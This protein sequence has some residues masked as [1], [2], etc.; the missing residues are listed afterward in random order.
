MSNFFLLKDFSISFDYIQN[1]KDE[2]AV[3][4]SPEFGIH[5]YAKDI[6]SSISGVAVSSLYDRDIISDKPIIDVNNYLVSYCG[7]QIQLLEYM[8]R[9]VNNDDGSNDNYPSV[10][11]FLDKNSYAVM[12]SWF[13]KTYFPNMTNEAAYKFYDELLL[14]SYNLQLFDRIEYKLTKEDFISVYDNT[15]STIDSEILSWASD[16]SVAFKYSTVS[17]K[18]TPA[19]LEN[20]KRLVLEQ[21]QIFYVKFLRETYKKLVENFSYFED[22]NF[23]YRQ[24][25]KIVWKIS[26]DILIDGLDKITLRTFYNLITDPEDSTTESQTQSIVTNFKDIFNLNKEVYSVANSKYFEFLKMDPMHDF[27]INNSFKK[28]NA[29]EFIKYSANQSFSSDFFNS[30]CYFKGLMPLTVSIMANLIRT[31]SEYLKCF[32]LNVVDDE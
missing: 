24:D 5:K 27:F 32:C 12:F 4:I 3:I 21:I 7:E 30:I 16:I 20:F 25:N 26:D 2:N 1:V 23:L 10:T 8:K 17:C 19:Q 28:F 9:H 13:F 11:F 22:A 6:D 15:L 18:Y 31:N 14:C 29:L